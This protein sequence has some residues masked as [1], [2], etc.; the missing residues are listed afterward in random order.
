MRRLGYALVIA[1]LFAAPARAAE[2]PTL[3]TALRGLADEARRR[4]EPQR[5]SAGVD[6]A[7]A[8]PCRPVT[9]N[10]ATRSFCGAAAQES[11]LAWRIYGCEDTM[12]A[13]TQVTTRGEHA[14]GRGRKAIT[15]LTAKLAHGVRLDLNE[16]AGRYDIVVWAPK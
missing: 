3:C 14:E 13:D 7:A 9:D 2:A 8:A 5:I 16:A 15:R 12:A 1:A 11:G 10:A 6:L 4:G